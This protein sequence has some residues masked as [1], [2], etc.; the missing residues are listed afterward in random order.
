MIIRE[1]LTKALSSA[2]TLAPAIP[3][4]APPQP[5]LFLI[6]D[7]YIIR[8]FKIQQFADSREEKQ[9]SS[10]PKSSYIRYQRFKWPH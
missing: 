9:K 6:L 2:D 10:V 8:L 3:L 1:K 5:V 7:V 4:A